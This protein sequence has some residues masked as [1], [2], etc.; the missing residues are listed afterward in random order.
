MTAQ[1]LGLFLKSKGSNNKSKI[2]FL[3]INPQLKAGNVLEKNYQSGF[4]QYSGPDL[5]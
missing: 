3:V 2:N 1:M 4:S 5:L